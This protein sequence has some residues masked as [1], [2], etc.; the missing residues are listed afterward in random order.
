MPRGRLFSLFFP[1]KCVF[2]MQLHE[3]GGVCERCA[4]QLPYTDGRFPIRPRFVERCVAPLYYQGLAREALLRFK[5]A[6]KSGYAETFAFFMS[7]GIKQELDG[8][9][10]VITWVPISR[11]RLRRRGYVQTELLA[12]ALAE[13]LRTPCEDMLRKVRHTPKQSNMRSPAERVANVSGAFAL[14]DGVS[15]AGRQILLVD[16]VVTT[17]ATMSEAARVLLTAGAG[18]V[19]GAAVCVAA[20]GKGRKRKS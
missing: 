18:R 6:G 4:R 7:A 5:F 8:K 9:Y 1:D 10:D 12:R 20:A 2:C 11:R 16:D 14:R 17:G 15:V 13:A 19:S 3:G